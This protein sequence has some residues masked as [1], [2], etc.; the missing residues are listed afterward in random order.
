[1][2]SLTRCFVL[3]LFVVN[4]HGAQYRPVVLMHGLLGAA[5]AMSHAQ[6]WIEADFPGIYTHNAEVGNGRDDSLWLPINQQ[7]EILAQGIRN[8]SKLAKGFNM[9]CHSQGA[10]LCRAY[11]ERYNSPPVY[12][13]I[14]WAGPHG[15]QY[16]VP[17]LNALC[18]DN[19]CP[20]LDWVMNAI[21]N[22]AWTDD[23]MQEHVSF[24]TYWKDPFA[25]S[26]YL[27]YNTFLADIN[28][29]RPTKNTTY[30]E[31]ML[32]LNTVLLIYSTSDNI[33]IPK[34]SPWF[35]QFK[36]NSDTVVELFN[37]TEQWQEDWLGLQ[38]LFKSSRLTFKSVP[39]G[40][41]DIPRDVCKSY[42]ELYTKPLLDNYL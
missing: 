17:D 42:Y 25:Y 18:P 39:C 34:T 27:K 12:N 9:V 5:E 4:I 40:H 29:E 37:Q 14:S 10:L 19:Y 22:G 41:Q 20:E 16:G 11:I 6:G 28:N 23:F 24:A 15:G 26:D 21:L 38:T 7:V 13:Y 8:D 1:M 2:K 31:N 30:K 32:S 35:Q 3:F 33:V 36:I